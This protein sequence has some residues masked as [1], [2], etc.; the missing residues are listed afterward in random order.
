V[1]GVQ[2]MSTRD[3]VSVHCF[4][5]VDRDF[6]DETQRIVAESWERIHAAERLI[7][8]IEARLRERYPHAVVRMRDEQAELGTP[9]VRTLY[10]FRD[11]RAA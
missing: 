7:A 8:D 1:E 6:H 2:D 3:G 11:G 4:P 9:S 10:A 5:S